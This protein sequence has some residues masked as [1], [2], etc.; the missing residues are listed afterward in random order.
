MKLIACIICF[1]SSVSLF[2][3]DLEVEGIYYNANIGKMVLTVTS[4]DIPYS[5]TMSIPES[6]EYKG[7]TFSVIKIEPGAFKN[8]S[9]ESIEVPGSIKTIEVETF[10]GCANLKKVKLS[11]GLTHIFEH[12]F[13]G[14]SSLTEISIP[15]TVIS[16]REYAFWHTGLTKLIIEDGEQ[17]LGLG[18][19]GS[20]DS[21]WSPFEFTKLENVYIGR[22]LNFRNTKYGPFK[23]TKVTEAVIGPQ[24]ESLPDYCFANLNIK[25]LTIPAGVKELGKSCLRIGNL[26]E[27][28]IEDSNQ[29]LYWSSYNNLPNLKEL[30]YGRN[31]TIEQN[32]TAFNE[33][34]KMMTLSIGE[35]VTDFYSV[36]FAGDLQTV[37]NYAKIPATLSQSTFNSRTFLN[38]TLFVPSGSVDAYSKAEVWKNFWEIK[39]WD[40]SGISDVLSKVQKLKIVPDG[41]ICT[42]GGLINIFSINGIKVYSC[43]AASDEFITL[44][45]G[46]YIVQYGNMTQKIVVK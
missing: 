9:I 33:C 19:Y 27:L 35:N 15:N 11:E 31:L 22:T 16:I 7:R 39:E 6:V 25:H 44:D 36:R 2:A 32:N 34:T 23:G 42:S 21:G 29:P 38:A 4:G 40:S 14:C 5:G 18:N 30:Y 20:S 43:C 45:S 46:L 17:E 37:Y 10:Q 8:S 28:R 12:S 1:L 3:Y 13:N 24:V 41:I 26:E